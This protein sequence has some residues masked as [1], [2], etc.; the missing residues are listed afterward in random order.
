MERVMKVKA[1]NLSNLSNDSNVDNER[2]SFFNF[3]TF[4]V[5]VILYHICVGFAFFLL[6]YCCNMMFGIQTL[7]YT[8]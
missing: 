2:K 1:S 6:N 8:N 7:F 3:V 4:V 5:A